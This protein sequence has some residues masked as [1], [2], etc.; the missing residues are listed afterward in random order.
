MYVTSQILSGLH[1]LSYARSSIDRS[2]RVAMHSD[3][4]KGSLAQQTH[5]KTAKA[6]S[7]MA[8]QCYKSAPATTI[9]NKL[10]TCLFVTVCIPQLISRQEGKYVQLPS[11]IK[12]EHAAAAVRQNGLVIV[13]SLG[14]NEG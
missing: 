11:L 4:P 6:L 1:S 7:A 2:D 9:T 13:R 12:R 3:Q 14:N 10:N 5:T 8:E